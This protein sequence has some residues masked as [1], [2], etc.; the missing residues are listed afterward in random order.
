MPDPDHDEIQKL[1]GIQPRRRRYTRSTPVFKLASITP[2]KLLLLKYLAECRFLSLPQLARLACLSLK[3]ARRHMRELFDNGFVD[4]M[5]I[6]RLAL[7]GQNDRNDEALLYGS[8]PNLYA[9]SGSGIK[10]LVESAV[11][12]KNLLGKANARYGP[13]NSLFLAHELRVRD[14]RVWL[15]MA[16]RSQPKGLKVTGW[17]DGPEAVL[18]VAA[19][20]R[21]NPDAWFT[22]MMGSDCGS[23]KPLVLVGLVEV[24]RGTERGDTRW[25]EKLEDYASL[26]SSGQLAEITGYQNARILVISESDTRARGL[27]DLICRCASP[28]LAERF[29][30]AP[31]CVL[32]SA[33]LSD[34]VWLRP[35]HMAS[36]PLIDHDVL[37]RVI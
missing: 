33:S 25:T 14:V 32:E 13:K 17:H 36:V 23:S 1:A 12:D 2:V 4:V 3:S 6:S 37:A 9:L 5:P 31:S 15:E 26:Y 10:F 22:L 30:I 34:T 29:W 21:V 27:A 20:G 16:V 8:A 35:H 7:A 19:H 24:D 28:A 18:N 11:S